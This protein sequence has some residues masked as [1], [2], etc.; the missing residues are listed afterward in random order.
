MRAV[1]KTF[2]TLGDNRKCGREDPRGS[3]YAK[4]NSKPYPW[5]KRKR[6]ERTEDETRDNDQRKKKKKKKVNKRTNE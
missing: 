3:G 1:G 6:E 5:R 2:A 4:S